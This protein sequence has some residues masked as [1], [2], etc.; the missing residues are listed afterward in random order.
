MCCRDQRE[1]CLSV[2][3]QRP[4]LGTPKDPHA[5]IKLAKSALEPSEEGNVSL[6]AICQRTAS[7]N[8]ELLR[9][10][11]IPLTFLKPQS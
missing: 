7:I 2:R 3:H 1:A 10:V 4:A 5:S 11:V 9:D 8:C 6:Q